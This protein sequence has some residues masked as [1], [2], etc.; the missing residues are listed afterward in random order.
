[1]RKEFLI[2]SFFLVV[3]MVVVGLFLP[4][5]LWALIL[6]GPA[7]ILGFYDFLQVK[8]T[9]RRNF[10]ILG[11]FRY[12]LELIRPE[13]NQYFIE[14]N[15]DGVPF[16]RE[17]R[18]VI[19]RRSKNKL[20]SVPFGM[21]HSMHKPG[22]EWINHSIS[23]KQIDGSGLSVTVGGPDCRQPYRASL[24][25][26]SAMSYGSISK[27]AVLALNGAAKDGNFAHN[28]GEGGISRYHLEPGGDLIWQI[29]TAYF[30]CR[31]ENGEFCEIAFQKKSN[32]P[33]VKMIEIKLSQGAK[34][35][36]GGL[37]PA[38]KVSK[39]ISE[40]RGVPIGK[41]VISPSTHSTFSTPVELM[42]FVAHLRE[43]SNAKPVG[44]KL[45]IGHPQEFF[46]I[47][48][49]MQKTRI[50]PDFITVDGG[51]GGTGAAP[52]EFTNY[53]GS[54][55][56]DSLIFVHNAL[57]GFGIRD[58]V[59]IFSSGRVIH[60]FD[61]IKML[62]LG[63]DIIYSA[64]AM[65]MALGCIQALRCNTNSCPTGVATQDPFLVEGLVIKDKRKRV[66]MFHQKTVENVAHLLGA[67]GLCGPN[68]LRPEHI[69]RRIDSIKIQNYGE[70]YSFIENGSLLIEPP[71]EQYAQAIGQACAESF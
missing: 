31:K 41:D 36:Y 1:M 55:G 14:S 65:M 50:T 5:A 62:A 17:Q 2:L 52:M 43:L 70:L 6:I 29:G 4:E 51:E 22:Y 53:V 44:F 61:V 45:C 28:T 58:K 56:V 60:G 19:Y 32:H 25:N 35:G 9:I 27:N 23:P 15:T 46:A 69:F 63:A 48:K 47:C 71:P 20:D 16:S 21:Q 40:I 67:I 57:T 37:L 7:L 30:G 26:I 8:H 59:R 34:P 64:R 42:H 13:I 39:E 12:W 33:H 3:I 54:P 24:L 66:K 10:P 68:E 38:Q 11:R 49:A 18:S